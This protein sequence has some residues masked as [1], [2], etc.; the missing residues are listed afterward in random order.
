MQYEIKIEVRGGYGYVDFPG[1]ELISSNGQPLGA[2]GSKKGKGGKFGTGGPMREKSKMGK[3]K[4][5]QPSGERAIEKG[6][7]SAAASGNG[8]RGQGE[9]CT[10]GKGGGII[11]L[12]QREIEKA[13]ES[14]ATGTRE[15]EELLEA[16]P[17]SQK[18]P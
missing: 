17:S 3:G 4:I 13:S 10:P 9:I 6:C 11:Q 15:C 1:T 7:F 2:Q 18:Q 5:G 16:G 8:L 12:S 14:T